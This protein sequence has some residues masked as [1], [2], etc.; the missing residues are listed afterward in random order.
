MAGIDMISGGH[1]QSTSEVLQ[2]FAFLTDVHKI[3]DRSTALCQSIVRL[4]SGKQLV[5]QR[6]N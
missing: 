4:V 6:N 3:S 1:V 5:C 2:D